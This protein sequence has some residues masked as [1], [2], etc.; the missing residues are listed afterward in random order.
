MRTAGI[1]V[2]EQTRR[3]CVATNKGRAHDGDDERSYAGR[4]WAAQD[5][6]HTFTLPERNHAAVSASPCCTEKGGPH[7]VAVSVPH[8]ST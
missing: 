1:R 3:E 7:P 8:R 2:I 6:I 4:E 5:G